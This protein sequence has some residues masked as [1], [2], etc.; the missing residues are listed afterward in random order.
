MQKYII[1]LLV[2]LLFSCAFEPEPNPYLTVDFQ[3][4]E[5]P[6]MLN[7][8][9]QKTSDK[10]LRVSGEKFYIH[11]I[12]STTNGGVTTQRSY[13]YNYG[14]GDKISESLKALLQDQNDPY[15]FMTLSDIYF[16]S[17]VSETP[18]S[19][20]EMIKVNVQGNYYNDQENSN[21]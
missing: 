21:E 16:Y 5:I 11:R 3:G 18:F 2:L 17:T 10:T 20:K 1:L 13:T 19:R 12:T 15:L 6:V 9:P 14:K 7:K 8:V 4:E